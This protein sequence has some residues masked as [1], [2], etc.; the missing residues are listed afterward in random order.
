MG[1]PV[2][3]S[4]P[5]EE[6]VEIFEALKFASERHREKPLPMFGGI[7]DSVGAAELVEFNGC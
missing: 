6:H 5:R 3:Q 7:V 4:I 1:S 2:L